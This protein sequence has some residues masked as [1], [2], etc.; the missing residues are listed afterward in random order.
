[1]ILED[2]DNSLTHWI[3]G[4]PFLRAYYAIHDME[5]KRIGFAGKFVDLGEPINPTLKN[6]TSNAKVVSED[7]WNGSVM[8]FAVGITGAVALITIIGLIYFCCKKE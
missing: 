2:G 8:W 4:S 1:M 6:L 5:S 3:L 7:W